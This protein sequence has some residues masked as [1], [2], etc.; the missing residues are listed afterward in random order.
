MIYQLFPGSFKL[1]ITA[2]W[3]KNLDSQLI[4]L[5]VETSLAGISGFVCK[6]EF[7]RKRGS[8]QYLFVNGRFMRHPYFHKAVLTSYQELIPDDAQPNYFLC[9]NVD[10]ETI[11]VNIHPTK[12]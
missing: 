10:P 8:L 5:N 3:G 12:Q 11:D 6:P 9:F 4:P 2:L 1:R 7:A